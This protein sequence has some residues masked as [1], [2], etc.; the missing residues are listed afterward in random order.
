MYEIKLKSIKENIKAIADRD[1]N[2]DILILLD[3]MEKT[4]IDDS[5]SEEVIRYIPKEEKVIKEML[6]ETQKRLLDIYPDYYQGLIFLAFTYFEIKEYKKSRDFAHKAHQL[7]N[8]L[9][10]ELSDW[11]FPAVEIFQLAN[12]LVG[13]YPEYL[14]F[15]DDTTTEVKRKAG[16]KLGHTLQCKKCG[17]FNPRKSKFCLICGNRFTKKELKK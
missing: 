4:K 7:L 16:E 8:K 14:E 12:P 17:N 15:L 9:G 11:V 3:L 10:L 5:I 13:E 6:I 2:I 1:K